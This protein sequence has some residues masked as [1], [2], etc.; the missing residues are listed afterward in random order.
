MRDWFSKAAVG[1]V[2]CCILISTS[3]AA[4]AADWQQFRG[5][6]RDGVSNEKGL[7]PSW[8]RGGPH[9]IWKT[10]GVGEGYS[11]ATIVQGRLYTQA[12]RGSRQYVL[13]FD[14]ESGKKIWETAA[15]PAFHHPQAGDGPRGT[16][17]VDSGRVYALGA[18]GS[19]VCLDATT[20]QPIWSQNLVQQYGAAVP[21]WGF[22][23]S[24]L[25]DGDRLIVMPGG[26]G[27]AVVALDK[28][29]GA[30][31]WK[32]GNDAAG[33][34]SAIVADI[35]D[36]HEIFALTGPALVAL[37]A[38]TGEVLWR[39]AKLFDRYGGIVTPIFHGKHVFLSAAFNADDALLKLDARNA[40]EVYSRHAGMP[41]FYYSVPVLVG[42][43]LYSFSNAILTAMDF[44]TGQVHWKDHSVGKGSLI[45]ADERLYVLSEDGVMALVAPSPDAYGEISRFDLRIDGPARTPPT[46]SAGRLYVRVQDTLYCYDIRQQPGPKP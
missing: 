35:D 5:P 11:S 26:R 14:A 21:M 19:L 24:P 33:H 40:T 3:V 8:P 37:R 30:L 43:T 23:E 13:A 20:G 22:S 39:Y 1:V 16:P 6:N 45:Y 34:A 44:T 29:T 25:I 4:L 32:A 31:K 2:A 17:S 10:A 41:Y 18:D 36:V 46:I 7:L 42:N 9:L 27:A 12:Q 28:A 15:G 38:D